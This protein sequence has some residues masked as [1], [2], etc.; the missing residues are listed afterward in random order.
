M[1]I[2]TRVSC[3][4]AFFVCA[5]PSTIFVILTVLLWYVVTLIA[6]RLPFFFHLGHF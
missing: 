4:N 5:P 3:E 6:L 2:L 1:V